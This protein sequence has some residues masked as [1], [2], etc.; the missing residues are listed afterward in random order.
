MFC[1]EYNSK[2]TLGQ[3]P[4]KI[5]IKL[6]IGELNKPKGVIFRGENK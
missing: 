2:E 1:L 6:Q 4:Q 3:Q 5:R